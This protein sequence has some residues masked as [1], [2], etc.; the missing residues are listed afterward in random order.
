MT[1]LRRS[2]PAPTPAPRPLLRPFPDLVVPTNTQLP[3]GIF[4]ACEETLRDNWAEGTYTAPSLRRSS[5]A[6]NP[7]EGFGTEV[8]SKSKYPWR[9]LWDSPKH[10]EVYLALG[11]DAHART[12]LQSLFQSQHTDGFIPAHNAKLLGL[13]TNHIIQPPML[14]SAGLQVH[15]VDGSLP[16]GTYQGLKAFHEWIAKKCD[17]VDGLYSIRNGQESG[18]DTSPVF[19]GALWGS[20]KGGFAERAAYQASRAVYDVYSSW[21]PA[22]L[23]RPSIAVKP[24][25]FNALYARD[26]RAMARLSRA[27][28]RTATG[29]QKTAFL[30]DAAL[31]DARYAKV[32]SS[33]RAKMRAADPHTPELGSDFLFWSLD[34]KGTPIQVRTVEL[35][36]AFAAG[37]LEP[38]EAVKLVDY[39]KDPRSGFWTRFPVPSTSIH[40]PA[41]D[42]NDYWR[43]PVWVDQNKLIVEGLLDYAH[44]YGLQAFYGVAQEIFER[45][46]EMMGVN[47][48]GPMALNEGYNT[49]TGTAVRQGQFS[50]SSEIICL[51]QLLRHYEAQHPERF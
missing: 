18:D 12:E 31:F 51:D 16:P 39:L 35:F 40:E 15:A 17:P 10:I 36:Q 27:L 6:D 8:R 43:G 26:L 14:G 30:A 20:K 48:P 11:Q 47:L 44:E 3:L 23:P 46:K 5:N 21:A 29:E 9:W 2:R 19:D 49:F 37:L 41:F 50:W 25:M 42:A 1:A 22:A 38:A 28:A 32:R 13:F 34:R 33:M 7:L 4:Q 45:S 24:V